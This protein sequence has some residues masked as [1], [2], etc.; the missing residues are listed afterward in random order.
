MPVRTRIQFRRLAKKCRH[1]PG[2]YLG[3]L[4]IQ[5]ET[6][7]QLKALSQLQQLSHGSTRNRQTG[8]SH[9]FGEGVSDRSF[10]A[11]TSD[12]SVADQTALTPPALDRRCGGIRHRLAHRIGHAKML[13][14]SS[15]RLKPVSSDSTCPSI[16]FS[17]CRRRCHVLIPNS[18]H[19]ALSFIPSLVALRR[20]S[21]LNS[22][23]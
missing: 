16:A 10:A 6:G 1:R 3:P 18:S 20:A 17:P 22:A 12:V 19:T 23:L 21:R 11:L 15:A 14:L 8:H 5:H 7:Y 9:Q 13:G 4:R 2:D